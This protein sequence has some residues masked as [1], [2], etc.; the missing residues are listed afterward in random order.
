MHTLISDFLIKES[1]IEPFNQLIK[2]CIRKL[3]TSN[4][5]L[6]LFNTR[7]MHRRVEYNFRNRKVRIKNLIEFLLPENNSSKIIGPIPVSVWIYHDRTH[8]TV[9]CWH[10]FNLNILRLALR[11]HLVKTFLYSLWT[12][13]VHFLLGSEEGNHIHYEIKKR[14]DFVLERTVRFDLKNTQTLAALK[15]LTRLVTVTHFFKI[16]GYY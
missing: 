9:L 15:K 13:I 3:Y 6:S 16:W 8:I 1:I 10:D 2:C 7:Q 14:L 4:Q 5:V 12:G 11:H